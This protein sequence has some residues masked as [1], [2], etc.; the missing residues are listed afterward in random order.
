MVFDPIQIFLTLLLGAS[1]FLVV[2]SVFR[3]PV[4]DEVPLHRR[5]AVAMGQ[6]GRN[7][8]F[9]QPLISPIMTMSLACSRRMDTP[10]LR[11]LTRRW[12]DGCG[13]PNAYS[14]E[15]Y[16]AICLI[17][18][19]LLGLFFAM[20][21]STFLGAFNL[22]AFVLMSMAGFAAP[23]WLLKGESGKRSGAIARQLPY[24]MD[25]IALMMGAG[26][27]F[28]EA[29]QTLIRE[30]SDD[31]LN[32]ELEIV[33]AEID[34][35]AK[36]SEAM[37]NMANRIP[38]DS[39]RSMIGAINQAESLGTPLAT[40]LKTQ[41]DM[42]R[43]QRSVAAEKVSASASLYI[44]YPTMLILIAVVMVMFGPMIINYFRGDLL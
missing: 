12:L 17:C 27:T 26:T 28:N 19:L 35:G 42:L 16:L 15:E 7:T 4:S 34:F 6:G 5:I 38:M 32:H 33:L 29:V 44:L 37:T 30:N 3:Y 21:G 36:R 23:L 14:V 13:N 24:T 22:L 10:R 25:L 18:G 41:S 31:P 11:R 39:L 43:M 20:I 40:I 9:E 1:V 8:V 2:W